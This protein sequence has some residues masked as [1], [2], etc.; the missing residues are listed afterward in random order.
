MI[1]AVACSM[2]PECHLH[3]LLRSFV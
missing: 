3:L 1:P 2:L